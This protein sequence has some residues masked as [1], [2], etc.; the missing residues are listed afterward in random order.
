MDNDTHWWSEI[1]LVRKQDNAIF[2]GANRGRCRVLVRRRLRPR[3]C[4]IFDREFWLWPR[5]RI[6]FLND[7]YLGGN[8][9]VLRGRERAREGGEARSEVRVG[10]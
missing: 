4:G 1:A 10:R 5:R 6:P 3:G 7:R 2:D 8:F 9:G